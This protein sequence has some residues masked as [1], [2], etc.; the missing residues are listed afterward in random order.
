MTTT[1]VANAFRV[2]QS[3]LGAKIHDPKD[4]G[5]D[6]SSMLYEVTGAAFDLMETYAEVWNKTNNS[7][8]VPV[9]GFQ[10]AVGLEPV[11]VNLE[12]MIDKFRL[13]VEELGTIW[14]EVLS[15]D[16]IDFLHHAKQLSTDRFSVPEDIWAEIVYSF[17]VGAHKKVMNK[18]HLLK[19]LTP[20]YMGR[21]ASFVIETRDSDSTEVEAKIEELCRIFENKKPLLIASWH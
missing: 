16:I 5:A 14:Q 8:A 13:G 15:P 12:R 20:L 17:A 18:Q 21:T 4:P 6:L 3:F 1:A 19:S 10:Y 11:S 7:E 9:Y 2:C